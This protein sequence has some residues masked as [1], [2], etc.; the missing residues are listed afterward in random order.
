[1]AEMH[2]DEEGAMDP[3]GPADAES[4][5]GE[6]SIPPEAVDA[7]LTVLM[8]MSKAGGPNAELY[9]QA[10]KALTEEVQGGAA[11]S[12]PQAEQAGS[13]PNAVPMR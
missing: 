13:N 9:M 10:G 1:M 11:P 3:G 2:G 7:A 4:G 8:M 12:G 5:A 6:D